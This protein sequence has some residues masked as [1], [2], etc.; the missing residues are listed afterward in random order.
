[1]KVTNYNI[2]GENVSGYFTCSTFPSGEKNIFIKEFE[3]E[4]LPHDDVFFIHNDFDLMALGMKA[5]ILHR[6]GCDK[7]S[8]VLPYLPYARQDRYTV[9]GASFSLKV[10]ANFINNL[11]FYRVYTVDA[12]SDVCGVINNIINLSIRP[13][14]EEVLS[15][16]KMP[17][18]ISPDAGAAKKIHDQVSLT[19]CRGLLVASKHRNAAT[20]EINGISVPHISNDNDILVIDDICDGGRTFIELAKILPSTSKKYLYVTHGIFS[21]GEVFDYYDQVYTTNSFNHQNERGNLTKLVINFKRKI[22]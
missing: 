4:R 5:D 11:G 2:D 6:A 1:M 22:R 8:L 13:I 16:F 7:V 14:L 21:K 15:N 10:F 12:H 19:E 3:H 17:L 18:I 20:G 9:N